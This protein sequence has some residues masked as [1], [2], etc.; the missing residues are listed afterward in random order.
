MAILSK[1]SQYEKIF[2]IQ[3]TYII[4]PLQLQIQDPLF[5][6]ISIN[7]AHLPVYYFKYCRRGTPFPM[8][9]VLYEHSLEDN[10]NNFSNFGNSAS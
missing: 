8:Q 10:K 9:P 6:N 4:Q 2:Y 3:N 1:S 5:L 7:F